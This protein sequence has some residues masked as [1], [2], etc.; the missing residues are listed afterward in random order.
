MAKWYG[1]VSEEL[2]AQFLLC[3]EKGRVNLITYAEQC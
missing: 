3:K 1:Q 2:T